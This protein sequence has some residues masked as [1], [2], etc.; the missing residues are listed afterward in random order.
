MIIYLGLHSIAHT[1]THNAMEYSLHFVSLA[2]YPALSL[3]LC[4]FFHYSTEKCIINWEIDGLNNHGKKTNEW[5]KKNE[6]EKKPSNICIKAFGLLM[7]TNLND[8]IAIQ[9]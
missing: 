9:Y 4:I 1:H 8:D 5:E 2:S 6:C 7:Q 3:W